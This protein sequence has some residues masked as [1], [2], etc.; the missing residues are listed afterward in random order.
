MPEY[1]IYE[2]SQVEVSS[3][4]DLVDIVSGC[5]LMAGGGGDQQFTSYPGFEG[6]CS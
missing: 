5:V 3:W 6:E 4:E 2:R 1:G